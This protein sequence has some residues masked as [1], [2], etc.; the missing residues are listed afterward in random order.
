[1]EAR[2]R[3][4]E[5]ELSRLAEAVAAIERRLGGV[6]RTV[7]GTG[8]STADVT[9]RRGAAEPPPLEP[10][11]ATLARPSVETPIPPAAEAPLGLGLGAALVGRILLALGGGFLLRSITDSALLPPAAGAAIGLAYALAWAVLAELAARRGRARSAI[12]HASTTALLG[13]P[14]AWETT[15]RFGL[16]PPLGAV[17]LTGA[18]A[19]LLLV[20]AARHRLAALS[21]LAVAAAGAGTL[22]ISLGARRPEPAAL[23]W[24]ILAPAVVLIAH[25]HGWRA[26]AWLAIAAT[27]LSFALVDLGVFV[28]RAPVPARAGL[29]LQLLLAVTTIAVTE[30]LLHRRSDHGW[31]TF[32]WVSVGWA[33]LAVGLLLGYGAALAVGARLLPS[34]L[35]A[36]GVA[37]LAV[38]LPLV[39]RRAGWPALPAR[40]AELPDAHA[41][42][43]SD[44]LALA[45]LAGGSGAS[46]PGQAGVAWSLAALVLAALA[47]RSLRRPPL[48]Q[49]AALA[50]LAAF[51]GGLAA[52]TLAA[53]TG[54]A[55]GVWGRASVA[56]ALAPLVAAAAVAALPPCHAGR[57]RAWPEWSEAAARLAAVTVALL[58][59]GTILL[60]VV[61][62]WLALDLDADRGA[63]A[64]TR[65]AALAMLAV[66]AAALSRVER[67]RHAAWLVYPLFA[68]TAIKLVL[69][70]LPH[71]RPATLFASLAGFGLALL[72][73]PRLARRPMAA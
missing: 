55:P 3:R 34:A 57:H 5:A 73:A 44:A 38:A 52:T 56:G 6:E 62:A 16:L 19:A 39:A 58:G 23:L 59:A 35:P 42:R 50:V 70:D 53:F 13:F 37:S 21:A 67:L 69:E 71:G 41:E 65:T 43:M 11:A 51:A 48:V 28:E 27:A 29:A 68:A 54:A 64:A 47:R 61:E 66:I 15:V 7:G 30:R 31:A 4:I 72:V 12:A 2:V 25:R 63:L 36:I 40:W 33:H 9:E 22:S 45:L 10:P 46:W 60:R 24:A 20:L 49:A 32:G 8:E 17:L 26:P 1:V 14:L 18:L